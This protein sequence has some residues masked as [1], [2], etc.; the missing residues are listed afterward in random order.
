MDLTLGAHVLEA[1]L[2]GAVFSAAYH[3]IDG[4]T[5]WRPWA[6]LAVLL[7]GLCWIVLFGAV[8]L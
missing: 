2:F 4:W 3:L 7:A 5:G 1:I 6:T 8:H